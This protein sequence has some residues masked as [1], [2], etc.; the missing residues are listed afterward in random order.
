MKYLR[1]FENLTEFP[2]T[3]DYVLIKTNIT[4]IL[5][6]EKYNRIRV[7]IDNT[8]GIILDYNSYR[9]YVVVKYENIPDDIKSYFTYIQDRYER[10]FEIDRI[11]AYGSTEEELKLKIQT[12][13]FNI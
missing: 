13:K 9:N 1:N 12:N 11:V 10:M 7:F 8:I 6:D 5:N 2:K 4:N 3:G